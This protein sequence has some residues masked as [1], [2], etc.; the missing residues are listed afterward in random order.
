MWDGLP[1]AFREGAGDLSQ[2]INYFTSHDVKDGRRLMNYIFAALLQLRGLG[3]GSVD[4]IRD[5]LD[6]LASQSQ[7]IKDAHA[8]TLDRI[9]SAHALLLTSVGIPMFLAGEE[10]ADAHDLPFDSD[11]KMSDPVNWYRRNLP[12]HRQLWDQVAE[13]VK[14]RTSHS[15]L[16]RNEVE[17]FYFH[18]D[19]DQN[20]GARAVAYARTGG[21]PV[22]AANE[23]AVIGNCGAESYAAFDIP[24]PWGGRSFQ[25]FGMPVSGGAPH[26]VAGQSGLR[27]S[28]GPF[29]FRVFAIQ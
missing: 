2:A 3:N 5:I 6:N 15:A 25:E 11:E 24:W 13:L 27:L 9:R 21:Q 28:L 17:F 18:P 12:G 19:T 1:Q 14:L 23:V 10:F 26:L 4:D 8:E 22:G 16:Q 29:Q 20:N 7:A